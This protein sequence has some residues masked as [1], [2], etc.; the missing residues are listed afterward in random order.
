[1]ELDEKRAALQAAAETRKAELGMQ[2]D[3]V[4]FSAMQEIAEIKTL[5]AAQAAA[6][7]ATGI[8]WLDAFRGVIRPG[9]A[10]IVVL[11]Y[12][13]TRGVEMYAVGVYGMNDFDRTILGSVLGWMFADRSIR[14]MKQ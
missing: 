10:A 2:A 6:N 5:A 1:M 7:A 8:R 13:T 4:K 9:T 3:T 12:V 11:F 14:H